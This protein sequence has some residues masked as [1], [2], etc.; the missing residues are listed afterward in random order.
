MVSTPTTS[1]TE[2][3]VPLTSGE[4]LVRCGRLGRGNC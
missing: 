3:I 4:R 1:T 2:A